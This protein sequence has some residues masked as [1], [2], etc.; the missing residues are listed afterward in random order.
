MM[1]FPKPSV[2]ERICKEF[3]V[4]ELPFVLLVSVPV[5]EGSTWGFLL[6]HG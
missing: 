6:L 2:F 1:A 5:W 4:A 3:A